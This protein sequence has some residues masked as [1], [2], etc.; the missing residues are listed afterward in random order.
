VVCY[1]NYAETLSFFCLG[2]LFSLVCPLVLPITT[3]YFGCKYTTD[4]YI[5]VKQYGN[6]VAQPPFTRR[7]RAVNRYALFGISMAQM[8]PCWFFLCTKAAPWHDDSVQPAGD[9]DGASAAVQAAFALTLL[10]LSTAAFAL[11]VLQK[12]ACSG[13]EYD[14]PPRDTHCSEKQ[15]SAPRTLRVPYVPPP[16]DVWATLTSE[17]RVEL[18]KALGLALEPGEVD[19]FEVRQ[20]ESIYLHGTGFQ[21]KACRG[22]ELTCLQCAAGIA[23]TQQAGEQPNEAAFKEDGGDD[24]QQS[25]ADASS[26]TLAPNIQGQTIDLGPLEI[27]TRDLTPQHMQQMAQPDSNTRGENTF[28]LGRFDGWIPVS[29]LLPHVYLHHLSGRRRRIAWATEAIKGRCAPKAKP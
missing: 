2:L 17:Q 28:H 15:L 21:D 9:D 11:H 5:L 27:E 12:C 18:R 24:L 6:A 20:V 4:K 13:R 29:Q 8:G 10:C 7:V 14:L 25:L 23:T 1:R 26:S 22:T 3:L 19:S 16:H